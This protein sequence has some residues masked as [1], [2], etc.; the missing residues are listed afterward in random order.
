MRTCR[1]FHL[2]RPPILWTILL[3]IFSRGVIA[4]LSYR[5]LSVRNKTLVH[6]DISWTCPKKVHIFPSMEFPGGKN[7]AIRPNA[8]ANNVIGNIADNGQFILVGDERSVSRYVFV[9][10]REDGVK[11]V[12]ITTRYRI[13]S[14]NVFSTRIDEFLK[15]HENGRYDR[16][17]RTPIFTDIKTQETDKFIRVDIILERNGRLPPIKSFAVQQEMAYDI[18]IGVVQYDDQML[19]ERVDGLMSRKVIWEGGEDYPNITILSRYTDGTEIESTY[20]FPR[21]KSNEFHCIQSKRRCVF[22]S[23]FTGRC[24]GSGKRGPFDCTEHDSP[25]ECDIAKRACIH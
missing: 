15:A 1:I 23:K 14:E 13:C 25:V 5:D 6:L 7:Y 3:I 12:R 11:Y 4:P 9:L 10:V 16:V 17:F 21:G 24:M 2:H 20:R 19:E 18:T 8:R 22:I